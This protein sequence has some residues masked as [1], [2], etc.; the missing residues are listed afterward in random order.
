[1][2]LLLNQGDGT[3]GSEEDYTFSANTGL[4][5]GDFNQD[6]LPDIGAGSGTLVL[7]LNSGK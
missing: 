1:M 6:G 4:V 5:A 3:F 7:L 2:T